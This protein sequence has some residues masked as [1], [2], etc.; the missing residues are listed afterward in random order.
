MLP[1]SW[2][3]STRC[4]IAN[5]SSR[6]W[7]RRPSC[8]AKKTLTNC[9]AR[10]KPT[11]VDGANWFPSWVVARKKRSPLRSVRNCLLSPR[12]SIARSPSISAT[13]TSTN[14]SSSI[15]VT[16]SLAMMSWDSSMARPDRNSQARLSHC[17]QVEGQLW[18][19]HPRCQMGHAEEALLRRCH[20]HSGHRPCRYVARHFKDYIFADE[21]QHPQVDRCQRRWCVRWNDRDAC[22]R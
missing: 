13:R 8:W 4:A 7:Q 3:N 15:A 17:C 5:T 20:P 14:I 18:Q 11:R 16:P 6:H 1:T 9:R 2:L 12:I 10:T 19:S 21:C 22:P